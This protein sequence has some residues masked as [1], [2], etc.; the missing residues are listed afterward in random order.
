MYFQ[1]GLE[2]RAHAIKSKCAAPHSVL[3]HPTKSLNC[4]HVSRVGSIV[5]TC[6]TMHDLGTAAAGSGAGAIMGIGSVGSNISGIIGGS[7]SGSGTS[8]GSDTGTCDNN[9]LNIGVL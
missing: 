7:G 5:S 4:A 2:Y 1:S 6:A 8:K 9:M 3:H